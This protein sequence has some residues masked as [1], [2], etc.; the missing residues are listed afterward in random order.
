M[1][2]MPPKTHTESGEMRRIGVEL[3]LHGLDLATLADIVADFIGGKADLQTAY[4]A[5]VDGD[6]AGPWRVEFDYSYLQARARREL[7]AE[8]E[9]GQAPDTFGKKVEDAA[10]DVLRLGAEQILPMEVVTPPLPLSRLPE[11]D[12]LIAKLRDAG[13]QGTRG[14]LLYAF[15]THLN[16]ELPALDE[17]T[18]LAYLRAFLCLYPWLRKSG[19]VDFARRLSLFIEPF[20]DRYTYK[21]CQPD[22]APSLENLMRD[23]L[24]S[25]P[26]RNRVLDMLPLFA[27]LDDSLVGEFVQD[28][29][30]KAR[31][32][33]H[34]RMPNCEVDQ[35]GWGLGTV[36]EDWL[37]V[38]H[39][40]GDEQ[41]LAECSAAYCDFLSKPAQNLLNDWADDVEPWLVPRENLS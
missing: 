4:E 39:L 38:E 22:Y 28:P 11:L 30:I 18:I 19:R 17:K 3:E 27:H 16:P 23:Y 34:Y 20:S 14:G 35:P 29:R 36:W 1:S 12:E 24:E 2:A 5:E 6:D 7:E 9:H 32:T 8:E 13:A 40:A 37:Q 41:R 10:E 33:L 25:N 21:V 15:G 26:T 31:P